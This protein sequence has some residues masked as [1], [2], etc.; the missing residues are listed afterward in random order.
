MNFISSYRNFLRIVVCIFLLTH[1]SGFGNSS[2]AAS[3]TV[4]ADNESAGQELIRLEPSQPAGD[5]LIMLHFPDSSERGGTFRL[6]K[7]VDQHWSLTHYLVA[8]YGTQ[9]PMVFGVNQL[10]GYDEFAVVGPGPDTVRLPKRLDPGNW[11]I[12]AANVSRPICGTFS[13]NQQ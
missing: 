3:P 9:A 10:S 13:V 8:A 6:E 5:Q 12:C 1:N 2:G 11:R 7:L 4:T